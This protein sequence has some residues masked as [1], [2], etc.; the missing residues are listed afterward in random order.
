MGEQS[1][2]GKCC[3]SDLFL[4]D[5]FENLSPIVQSTPTSVINVCVVWKYL[6][7]MNV[8]MILCL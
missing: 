7:C 6:V 1:V 4:L 2:W 8:C 3:S 5:S